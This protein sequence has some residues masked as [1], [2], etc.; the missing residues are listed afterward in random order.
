[1]YKN[2]NLNNLDYLNY[3]K[4]YKL[5]MKDFNPKETKIL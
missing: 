4:I 1:M 2:V 5:N 3:E